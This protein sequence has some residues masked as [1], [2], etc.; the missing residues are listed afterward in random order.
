MGVGTNI[1]GYSHP[2]IDNAVL[3]AVKSGNLSTVNTPEEVLWQRD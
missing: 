2:E 1:L 3:K